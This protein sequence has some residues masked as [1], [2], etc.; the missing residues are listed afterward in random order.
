M[1]FVKV[2][3]AFIKVRVALVKVGV[4]ISKVGVAL[5]LAIG[6]ALVKVGVAMGLG[7]GHRDW[8]WPLLF[9]LFFSPTISP[10]SFC[11]L[12]LPFRTRVT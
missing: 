4:A 2:R 3:V 12:F 5:Q 6:V 7:D 11:C 9:L 1:A 8:G 10:L